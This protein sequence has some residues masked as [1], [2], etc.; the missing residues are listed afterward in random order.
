MQV[1]KLL[2]INSIYLHPCQDLNPGLQVL[3]TLKSTVSSQLSYPFHPRV[4]RLHSGF[5]VNSCR[6]T[7]LRM[8]EWFYNI[9]LKLAPA[10]RTRSHH[11]SV[12]NDFESCD[13]LI[14]PLILNLCSFCMLS[15]ESCDLR[16]CPAI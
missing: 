7:S 8:T 3:L 2:V 11:P 10:R 13:L 1:Y 5:S 6:L 15:C 4:T 14:C 12:F 16:I 9:E